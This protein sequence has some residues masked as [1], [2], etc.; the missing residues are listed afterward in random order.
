M[1]DLFEQSF[2]EYCCKLP[3]T[4][5]TQKRAASNAATSELAR[6]KG[7]RFACLQEPGE[8]EKLNVGLMKELTGGDKIMARQIYKEP[9]EFKPQFKMILTCNQLP[10]VPA[11]DNGTWRRLRVVEFTSRFVETPNPE[12]PN[13]FKMDMELHNKFDVWREYFM[14][15]LILYYRKY[16]ENGIE[17][18]EE[19]LA[20]TK[21]YQRNNDIYLDFV[22]Q[23]LERNDLGFT[24]LN[25]ITNCFRSWMKDNSI[26]QVSLKKRDVTTNFMKALGK[27]VVV[28]NVEGYKGWQFKTH[29]MEIRDD[30]EVSRP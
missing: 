1:V 21:E 30:L 2:G 17:E 29:G 22:E 3:I 5:L 25:Q 18:P 9:I 23:E 11:N 4:L 24:S 13:E 10:N 16:A 28:S 12:D 27:T 20:C 15:L 26:A 8:D 19:V 14:G 7:K 6:T